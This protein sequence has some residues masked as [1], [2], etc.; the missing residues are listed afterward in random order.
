V[1]NCDDIEFLGSKKRYHCLQR[2]M[3][4]II[5]YKSGSVMFLAGIS[6][7]D[8]NKLLIWETKSEFS[9]CEL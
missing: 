8:G 9:L 5:M 2:Y 3:I 6:P 4:F 7:V 1:Q